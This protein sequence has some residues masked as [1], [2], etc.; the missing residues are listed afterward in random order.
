M[1]YIIDNDLHIH[2]KLSACSNDEG[3]TTER[4][5]QYAKDNGLKTICLADH[6]WDETVKGASGWYMPQDFAHISKAKPLPQADGIRFLF[7]C[8]TELNKDLTLGL[9]KDMMNLILL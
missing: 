4:I 3:Q 7:G 1:K 5:L 6:F 2:S 9:S 8:E